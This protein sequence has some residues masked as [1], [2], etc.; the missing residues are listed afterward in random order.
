LCAQNKVDRVREKDVSVLTKKPKD[1]VANNTS[2]DKIV[3]PKAALAEET[4][5]MRAKRLIGYGDILN[6]Y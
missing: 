6:K 5:E 4:T 2:R 1:A 3:T